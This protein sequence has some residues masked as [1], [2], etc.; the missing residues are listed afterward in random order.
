[1]N[2]NLLAA[3]Q[4]LDSLIGSNVIQ[5]FVGWRVTDVNNFQSVPS[6]SYTPIQTNPETVDNANFQRRLIIGHD[7]QIPDPTKLEI[8]LPN[9]FESIQGICTMRARVPQEGSQSKNAYAKAILHRG[10]DYATNVDLSTI[11]N[12]SIEHGSE[13]TLG[14]FFGSVRTDA[15]NNGYKLS[16]DS[17]YGQ[18][19]D[20]INLLL[21]VNQ[22]GRQY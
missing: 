11:V 9:S 4:S 7:V 21:W 3:K 13:M 1:M 2:A 16:I 14:F 22:Y 6:E 18:V 20:E 19:F 15:N 17:I 12:Y 8:V 10:I 5:N